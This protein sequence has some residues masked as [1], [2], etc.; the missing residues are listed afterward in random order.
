MSTLSGRVLASTAAAKERVAV[1]DRPLETDRRAEWP[2]GGERSVC[3][4]GGRAEGGWRE[5]GVGSEQ[6]L[7]Q[8]NQYGGGG[9]GGGDGLPSSATLPTPLPFPFHSIPFLREL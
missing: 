8:E 9:D 5:W 1:V 6:E 2:R 3:T 4:A 7:G